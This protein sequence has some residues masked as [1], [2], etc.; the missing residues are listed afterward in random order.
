MP[1][2]TA[3]KP[4]P[5]PATR[6]RKPAAKPAPVT[7]DTQAEKEAGL[8]KGVTS[9]KPQNGKAR[10]AAGMAKT[11]KTASSKTSPAPAPKPDLRSAKQEIARSCMD[12]LAPV[13]KS[14]NAT[15]AQMAVNWFHH[16]P[17]GS[18]N[19]KR[20]WPAGIPTPQRSDWR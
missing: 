3:T 13:L 8:L 17:T 2:A 18:E 19:G 15:D 16:L 7:H 12:A 20:Y 10:I 1:T 9:P 14:L 6:T 5:K 11:S 4:T